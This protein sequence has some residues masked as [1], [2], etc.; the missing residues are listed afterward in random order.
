VVA[1]LIKHTDDAPNK[2]RGAMMPSTKY[3]D[4][5]IS[6]YLL[7]EGWSAHI[8]RPSS[9]L[10]MRNGMVTATV[11]EGEEVLLEGARAR[12][13]DAESSLPPTKPRTVK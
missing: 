1:S 9:P 10:I 4:Y 6:Y 8:Y 11:E 13:D 7:S 5:R 3:R 12:I 2:K